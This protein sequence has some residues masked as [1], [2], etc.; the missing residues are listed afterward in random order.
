MRDIGIPLLLAPQIQHLD[1]GIPVY[2]IHLGTQ[3]IIKI[4][5]VFN[6]GRPDEHRPLA[7]RATVALLKEGT[8]TRT[9]AQIAE[10]ID[11]YGGTLSIPVQLDTSNVILCCLTKHFD[12]LLPLLAE[13]V[14]S[15][16]FPKHEL[17]IF[18]ENNIQRLQVELTKNEVLT[19]RK[20]TEL[21][22]GDTHPYGYNSVEETY[23]S[24][25]RADLQQHFE[26][27]LN[28]DRCSIFLSGKIDD[29]IIEKLNQHLGQRGTKSVRSNPVFAKSEVAAQKI[30]IINDD[31]FQTAIKIGC[32]LFNRLHED[33]NGMFVLNTVLGGYFGSRLMA[34]VR[35][36]K[37]FT[38]NIYSSFDTMLH[39]GYFY[40]STEI[41]NDFVEAT[42]E[43]IYK[44]MSRLQTE[45]VG[46][47]ELQMLR[48]Y[49]LGNLLTMVDGPF[50]MAD[51]IKTLLTENASI[52]HFNQLGTTIKNIQADELQAL[53]QKYFQ[54][55][56][57]WE[58][59]AGV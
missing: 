51:T 15:P 59:V 10:H 34:N 39:D 38:Y 8:T 40:V 18:V 35:E 30:K 42:R 49:L 41:G 16:S 33:Y 37:G 13:L 24:L 55:A 21:I 26:E 50:N 17:D 54:S 31:T 47:A 4:E 9:S 58:V 14:Q 44:E 56:N 20:L 29:S 12:R 5:I 28:P 45:P 32:Q 7:A 2:S 36:D 25:T 23:T 1:N 22:F 11:F 57:M 46:E 27:K 3:D 52:E 43:E 6:S 19:Y 48:N 53:A